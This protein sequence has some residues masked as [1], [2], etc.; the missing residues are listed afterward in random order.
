MWV[1]HILVGP[2]PSSLCY[3]SFQSNQNPVNSGSWHSCRLYLSELPNPP[4]LRADVPV[5]IRGTKIL[6]GTM[7]LFN[8]RIWQLSFLELPILSTVRVDIPVEHN[9]KNYKILLTVGV[10]IPADCSF[11]SYQ[12][13]IT[14]KADVPKNLEGTM[15]PANCQSW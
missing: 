8:Y 15:L 13:P 1:H 5:S 9:F 12:I 11:Q 7:L 10:D 6:E 14:W 2:P 3:H 4:I